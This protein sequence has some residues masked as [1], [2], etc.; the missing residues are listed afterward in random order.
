MRVKYFIMFLIIAALLA[1]CGKNN[2]KTTNTIDNSPPPTKEI[3]DINEFQQVYTD[4]VNRLIVVSES[5]TQ[6]YNDWSSGQLSRDGYATKVKEL[7]KETKRLKTEYTYNVV[8][9]LSDADK[10]Q[11]NYD[12]INSSYSKALNEL[13]D[14]LR[15]LQNLEEDKIETAYNYSNKVVNDNI[16]KLKKYLNI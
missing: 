10:E 13:N 7:Y 6:A 14:V 15:I 11:A 5:A 16:A 3:T 1:G 8:F 2:A 9:K 12:L 4:W